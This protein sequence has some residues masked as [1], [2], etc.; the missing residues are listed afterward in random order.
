MIIT[1]ILLHDYLTVIIIYLNSVIKSVT[2]CD[3][4]SEQ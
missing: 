4:H 2:K 3:V 1:E